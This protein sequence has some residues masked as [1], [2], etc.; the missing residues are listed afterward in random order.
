MCDRV[1]AQKRAAVYAFPSH[2]KCFFVVVANSHTHLF[3]SM[4]SDASTFRPARFNH[5]RCTV[6]SI[7]NAT[8]VPSNDRWVF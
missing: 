1:S 8:C 6:R 2:G 3:A 4:C 7:K 5:E